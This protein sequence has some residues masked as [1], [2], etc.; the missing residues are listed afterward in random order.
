MSRFIP[1]REWPL[2]F[3]VAVI[4]HTLGLPLRPPPPPEFTTLDTFEA[5][6]RGTVHVVEM[7]DDLLAKRNPRGLVHDV[8]RLDGQFQR[9][10]GV[11][12]RCVPWAPGSESFRHIG[13]LVDDL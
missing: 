2:A 8:V 11:E 7:S 12:T 3:C 10:R 4:E 9:V 1:L 13:L 5:A 6:G